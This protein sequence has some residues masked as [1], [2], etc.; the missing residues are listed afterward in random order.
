MK[1]KTLLFTALL[2]A[3][4]A[5]TGCNEE[6]FTY[7]PQQAAGEAYNPSRPVEITGFAP[8][9]G[10]FR[11]KVVITGSNFGNDKEK[12][13]VFF[14]DGYYD[15]QA[16]IV[17][18]DGTSIYCLAPRQ[19]TGKNKIKIKVAAASDTSVASGTFSY[20]AVEM[21][22][23]VAGA[24]TKNGTGSKHSDGTLADADFWKVQALV[25]LGGEYEQIMTFGFWDNKGPYVRLVSVKENKVITIQ[26][27]YFGKP[28]IN[29]AKTRVYATPLNPPY[30]VYEYKK[31]SGW[32][33]YS[34]GEI[35]EM[36]SGYDRIRCLVMMDKAHD[37]NEEWL[38][39]CHKNQIFGRF[40][41]NTLQTDTLSATLDVPVGSFAGYLVY[42]KFKDCFYVSLYGAYS[43]YK[44][45]KNDPNADW[46]GE[47]SVKA[48]L[49]A[50]SPSQSTVVDG[51]LEDA[52]FKCPMGMCMDENGNIYV[53]EGTP[54]DWQTSASAHII[55]KISAI[56]G[57][58]STVVGINGVS[59]RVDGVPGEAT[60]FFP[61][62]ISYDDNGNFYI[63]EWWESYIRK[64]AIE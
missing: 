13:Q 29:E 54:D 1:N 39:F 40:N 32:M 6:T 48:E 19:A 64:Y 58:V 18:V 38:Y 10:K 62:D 52:R 3:L 44:I 20:K 2:T 53:C 7:Q 25:A 56:D 34:I 63:A 60:L 55:R 21:V 61:Q 59:T 17:S 42:D 33:P 31:E 14:D 15:N 11:E 4:T 57:Y 43:I 49:F 37:P 27:G 24:G 41:I 8:D 23:W 26:S 30:S 47:N 5:L 46:G 36:G 16:T 50:G 28:A 51:T 45:T 9:S 12:I 22:S 35:K